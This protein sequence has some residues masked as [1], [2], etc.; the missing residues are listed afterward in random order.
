MQKKKV[1]VKHVIPKKKVTVTSSVVP[2][3]ANA[4]E[5]Q[6][7]RKPRPQWFPRGV[8]G[9]PSGKKK[10]VRHMSTLLREAL[11]GQGTKDG[12][13]FDQ[14]IVQVILKKALSGNPKFVEMLM[15]YIDGKPQQHVVF[16]TQDEDDTLDVQEQEVLDNILRKNQ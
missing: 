15:N 12:T 9:N 2:V 5:M 6:N 10:G 11:K 8:S 14:A 7:E 16:E 1:T 4:E 13:P 3:S